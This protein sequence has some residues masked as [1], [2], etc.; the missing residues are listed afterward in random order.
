MNGPFGISF[1]AFE[2]RILLYFYFNKKGPATAG[3]GTQNRH[4][5]RLLFRN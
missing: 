2:A 1:L 4:M 3:P 5:I